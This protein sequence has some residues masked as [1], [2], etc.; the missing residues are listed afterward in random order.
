MVSTIEQCNRFYVISGPT[1]YSLLTSYH[2]PSYCRRKFGYGF[3]VYGP[4]FIPLGYG[5]PISW[6]GVISMFFYDFYDI[7]SRQASKYPNIIVSSYRI[8]WMT[9]AD[10]WVLKLCVHFE[11]FVLSRCRKNVV[12]LFQF[13]SATCV[14]FSTSLSVVYTFSFHAVR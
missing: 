8:T 6:L 11:K 1:G 5:R 14:H 7:V 9:Y 4:H 13:V 3:N 10:P 2:E 12:Q